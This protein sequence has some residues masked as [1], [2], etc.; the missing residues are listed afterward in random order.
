MD[1]FLILLLLVIVFLLISLKKS[2]SQ[3]FKTLH[4]KIDILTAE[5]KK[6]RSAS[7]QSEIKKSV[8]ED[9]PVQRAFIKP[10]TVVSAEPSKKAPEE[11]KEEIKKNVLDNEPHLAL[12]VDDNDALLFYRKIAQLSQ[13]NLSKNSILYFEINQYLG[14]EMVG[15]LE[16]MNFK[17]V[18]LRKDIYGNDRMMSCVL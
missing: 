17:N 3:K 9:E 8:L 10:A 15:L 12:F 7:Q 2:V 16:Q 6:A 4:D 5:L 1:E 13:K 14:K 18:E 11:Q